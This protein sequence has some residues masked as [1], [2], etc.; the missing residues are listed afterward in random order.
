MNFLKPT[1]ESC[2]GNQKIV[3]DEALVEREN[4]RKVF[5]KRLFQE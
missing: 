4:A 1:N 5:G 2:T 3:K